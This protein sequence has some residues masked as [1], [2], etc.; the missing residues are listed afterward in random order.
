MINYNSK[1]KIN[2]IIIKIVN[3]LSN[4]LGRTSSH[5]RFWLIYLTFVGHAGCL[6][7][8]DRDVPVG[9]SG[10]ILKAITRKKKALL[11]ISDRSNVDDRT[12]KYFLSEN[13]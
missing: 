6:I 7:H 3:L 2:K 1:E 9:M 12:R 5:F 8:I 4:E 11:I 10:M 13:Q